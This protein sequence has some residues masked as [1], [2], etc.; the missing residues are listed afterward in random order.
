[1]PQHYYNWHSPHGSLNGKTPME[2][3]FKLIDKNKNFAKCVP[4]TPTIVDKED[5]SF[6]FV[7]ASNQDSRRVIT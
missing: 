3:H 2:K 6:E 7:V 1:M 4:N 5:G